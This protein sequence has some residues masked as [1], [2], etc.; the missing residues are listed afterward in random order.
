MHDDNLDFRT[1]IFAPWKSALAKEGRMPLGL[2]IK[3]LNIS[4]RKFPD[5]VLL[6]N[7]GS[8]VLHPTNMNTLHSPKTTQVREYKCWFNYLIKFKEETGRF[9]VFKYLFLAGYL[10]FVGLSRIMV[11]EFVSFKQMF[12]E[13][14][15]EDVKSELASIIPSSKPSC[16][17]SLV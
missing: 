17:I 11:F 2:E 6:F 8:K 9:T 16:W 10:G 4:S 3:E 15:A 13:H 12:F 5:C 1:F 7:Q 14:S